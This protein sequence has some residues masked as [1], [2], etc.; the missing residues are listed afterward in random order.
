MRTRSESGINTLNIDRL[1]YLFKTLNLNK[2]SNVLRNS[3]DGEAVLWIQ[4]DSNTFYMKLP[5][6][7][8]INLNE[9]ED[10]IEKP[11]T[12]RFFV[13]VV[14]NSGKLR[15][16]FI[17]LQSDNLISETVG[18]YNCKL[19]LSGGFHPD[20]ITN[21]NVQKEIDCP[22]IQIHLLNKGFYFDR[23]ELSKFYDSSFKGELNLEK[24]V[25]EISGWGSIGL[26][27]IADNQKST[28]I[29]VHGRYQPAIPGQTFLACEIDVPMLFY[30]C[31]EQIIET[32]TYPT[33]SP[34]LNEIV[35][36][37]DRRGMKF[38]LIPF[39]YNSPDGSRAEPFKIF[40]PVADQ[41]QE[42]SMSLISMTVLLSVMA[43]TL[44][45][46]LKAA[47]KIKPES[48]PASNANSQENIPKKKTYN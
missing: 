31:P 38:R 19:D 29:K 12:Q 23:Y 15:H 11:I 47:S 41:N 25:Y 46:L 37:F 42:G 24:P 43:L 34:M 21:L 35:Q 26:F 2:L 20:I 6:F 13:R 4:F 32:D 16:N 5:F 18:T 40:L 28:I 45:G 10:S 14:G 44:F 48:A 9:L 36:Q 39:K 1:N 7:N 33:I 30:K 27:R 22:I 8:S 17:E 3:L